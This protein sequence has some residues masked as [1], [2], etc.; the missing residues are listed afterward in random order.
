M[1]HW[2][3]LSA[4]FLGISTDCAGTESLGSDPYWRRLLHYKKDWIGTE[5]SLVDSPQFFFSPHGKQDPEAELKATIDSFRRTNPSTQESANQHPQCRFPERFRFLRDRGIEFPEVLACPDFEEWKRALNVDS[6][7]L[8]F[9]SAYAHTPASLFGHTFLRMNAGTRKGIRDY[10]AGFSALTTDDSLVAYAFKGV[11]GGYP[12]VFSVTPYYEKLNEYILV[13]NRDIWEFDLDLNSEA[14]ERMVNHLWELY[15]NATFDYYYFDENCSYQLLGLLEVARPDWSITDFSL[16]VTPLETLRRVHGVN[17]ILRETYRP[18]ARKMLNARL[19][20]L[21]PNEKVSFEHIVKRREEPNPSHGART[22]DAAGAYFFH[23]KMANKGKTE[24]NEAALMHRILVARS[25]VDENSEALEIA[26]DRSPVDGH[27]P[28]RAGLGF[29]RVGRDT[30]A[31]FRGRLGVH[32]LLNYEAGYSPFS[33]FEFMDVRLRYAFQRER[34]YLSGI[35]FFRV[36]SITPVNTLE[37]VPSYQLELNYMNVAEDCDGRC[38]APGATGGIGPAMDLFG[39]ASTAWVMA[40]LEWRGQ[41]RRNGDLVDG[42]VEAAVLTRW[43]RRQKTLF[44]FQVMKR[45]ANGD[46]PDWT[47]LTGITHAWSLKGNHELRARLKWGS[48][49]RDEAGLE[50][51]YFF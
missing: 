51:N 9:A 7:T 37:K 36:R 11:F 24:T 4:F 21:V 49:A 50:W 26:K 38:L 32:D 33:E 17:G 20:L 15:A 34:L 48:R 1:K 43:R 16:Y 10:G 46:P 28:Y 14:L 29:T 8:I 27:P 45:F 41:S 5:R 35:Q 47:H 22:L 2:F 19:A 44:D 39:S 3:F 25:Q 31:E 23:K 40:R 18:S 13:E 30:L 12:G 42:G 6:A